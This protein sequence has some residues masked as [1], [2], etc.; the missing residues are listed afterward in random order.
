MALTPRT[1]LRHGVEGSVFGVI[2]QWPVGPDE[3]IPQAQGQR[4]LSGSLKLGP[5]I[6]LPCG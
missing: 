4:P 2:Q 3:C 5:E 6:A 1:I